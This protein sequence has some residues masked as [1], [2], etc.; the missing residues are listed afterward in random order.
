[1]AAIDIVEAAKDIGKIVGKLKDIAVDPVRALTFNNRRRGVLGLSRGGFRL[2][3]RSGRS[4]GSSLSVLSKAKA[5]CW[6]RCLGQICM[7]KLVNFLS[8]AAS[9]FTSLVE[10][11]SPSNSTLS[12]RL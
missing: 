4:R 6:I 3:Q 5:R 11:T 7:R 10:V 1:M 12:G 2:H 8:S 9:H